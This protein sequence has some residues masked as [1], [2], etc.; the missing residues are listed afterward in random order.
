VKTV[1]QNGSSTSGKISYAV[2]LLAGEDKP[3][4]YLLHDSHCKG[5]VTC[6][7][8]C[9]QQVKTFH[10]SLCTAPHIFKDTETSNRIADDIISSSTLHGQHADDG[11]F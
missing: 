3:E 10:F 8:S 5:A 7:F 2:G 4:G 11:K 1:L 6:T 9:S